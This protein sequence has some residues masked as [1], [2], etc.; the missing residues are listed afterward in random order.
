ME[1][2]QKIYEGNMLK[3]KRN[4]RN[5]YLMIRILINCQR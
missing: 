5:K 4:K 3:N 1:K 2:L